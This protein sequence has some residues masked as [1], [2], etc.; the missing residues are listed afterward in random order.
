MGLGIL[1]GGSGPFISLA[2]LFVPANG[3]GGSNSV[4][5]SL[6]VR[7]IICLVVVGCTSVREGAAIAGGVDEDEDEAEDEDEELEIEDEV[8]SEDDDDDCCFAEVIRGRPSLKS[9]SKVALRSS[10]TTH[11]FL[12]LH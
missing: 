3:S 6:P 12:I 11:F 4:G 10:S 9:F 2:G 8:D 1:E 5:L 7:S